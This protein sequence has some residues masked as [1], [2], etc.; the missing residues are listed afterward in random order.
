MVVAYPDGR[1]ANYHQLKES[2]CARFWEAWTQ[3]VE[4]YWIRTLS[5][6]PADPCLIAHFDNLLVALE[7]K[8]K[9]VYS[10]G[11]SKRK[12]AA[13]SL[14]VQ[15]SSSKARSANKKHSGGQES[16]SASD[17]PSKNHKT[18]DQLIDLIQKRTKD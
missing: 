5:G 18:K 14:G 7:E 6:S 12:V 13:D 10:L 8:N 2:D 16:S 11:G 1:V 15:G 9:K 4:Q 17:Q 3:K